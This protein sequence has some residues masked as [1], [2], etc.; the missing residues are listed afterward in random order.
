M[1]YLYLHMIPNKDNYIVYI[2]Y[3]NCIIPETPMDTEIMDNEIHGGQSW[4]TAGTH[5]ETTLG[6]LRVQS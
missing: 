1:E 5:L 6:P 4:D 2:L 3:T